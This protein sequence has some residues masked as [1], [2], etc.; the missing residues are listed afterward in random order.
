[1][2]RFAAVAS[3]PIIALA[4]AVASQIASSQ[5]VGYLG[6]PNRCASAH[7]ETD[8]RAQFTIV[9][10]CGGRVAVKAHFSDGSTGY[11]SCSQNKTCRSSD[12]LAKARLTFNYCI[13]YTESRLQQQYGTCR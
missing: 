11:E 10:N 13:E 2:N 9:N 7:W 6:P 4:S 12:P 1:M 8:S 5:N 3:I